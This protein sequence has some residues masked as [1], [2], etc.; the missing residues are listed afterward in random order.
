[1]VCVCVHMHT[2]MGARDQ[3]QVSFSTVLFFFLRYSLYSE[4]GS[5]YVILAVL[6]LD[7]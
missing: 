7:M 3:H 1:M 5:V 4:T 2:R 6:E